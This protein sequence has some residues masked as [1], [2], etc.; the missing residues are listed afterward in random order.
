MSIGLWNRRSSALVVYSLEIL[1]SSAFNQVGQA[2]L[3]QS[4]CLGGFSNDRSVKRVHV[5][6]MKFLPLQRGE[7]LGSVLFMAPHRNSSSGN[8]FSVG[9]SGG[10]RGPSTISIS[11]A[12][13]LL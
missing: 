1:Q 3:L 11:A 2:R 10:L 5:P 13:S 9:E 12:G 8:L 4:A 7:G 6:A